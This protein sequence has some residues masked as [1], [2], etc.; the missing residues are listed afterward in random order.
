MGYR[1]FKDSNGTDWQMWDV[2]PNVQLTERRVTNR[3]LALHPRQQPDRRRAERRVVTGR[4][5]VLG[6]GLS[7]GW[8]CFEALT[9]KRRLSPIPGDWL[10]CEEKRLEQYCR[11]AK[12]AVRTSA[13]VD[14]T[15]LLGEMR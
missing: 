9:E 5:P 7:G 14:I 13:A 8:L 6:A 4:R 3:R 2:V 10:R 1:A 11:Q 15:T 12:P